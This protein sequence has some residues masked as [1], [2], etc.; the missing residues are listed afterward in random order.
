MRG[1]TWAY[2]WKGE[3]GPFAIPMPKKAT[4][5]E[6]LEGLKKGFQD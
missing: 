5:F 6:Y 3:C 1:T 4:V 2:T